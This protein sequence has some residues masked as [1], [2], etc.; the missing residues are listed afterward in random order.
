[1]DSLHQV[2][3]KASSE[4]IYKALTEQDGIQSWWSEH[5]KAEPTV[6]AVNEVSFYGGMVVFMI[7]NA[8]L[9]AG[10]EVVWAVEGGAPPWV[11]TDITWTMSP[12]E[13]PAEGQTILDFAHRGLDLPEGPFASINYTWGWYLTS[14]KFYLEK[15]E[16]MPHTDADIA[17]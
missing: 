17:S 5:S 4:A 10:K 3:I 13:G 14:L 15:G 2:G 8:S 7:R 11:G 6:D 9:T 16:G 12:G 1:M